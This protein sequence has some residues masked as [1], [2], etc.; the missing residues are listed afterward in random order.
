MLRHAQALAHPYSLVFALNQATVLSQLR[1]DGRAVQEQADEVI[2]VCAAQGLSQQGAMATIL[3]GWGLVVQGQGE[4]GIAQ[5]RH[6][7]AAS[8][9]VGTGLGRAPVLAQMADAYGHTGQLEAGL[10]LLAE[11]RVVMD[12]TEERWWEAEVHRL[13]G[14][15]LWRYAGAEASQAEPCLLHALAVA[16]YQQAK[17]LE[18]RVAMSLARLWQQQDQLA[19]ANEV[20]APVYNWFTEGFDT[21][22]LQEAKALLDELAG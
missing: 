10:R 1:R 19:K 18:L 2:A 9:A 3:R 17:S 14:D 13:R 20:L 8:E 5:M 12:T 22:D 15:L 21:A 4:T 7:L 6:G 11:A 16:R